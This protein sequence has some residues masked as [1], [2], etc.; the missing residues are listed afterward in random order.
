MARSKHNAAY[1]ED[2]LYG[3]SLIAI[4]EYNGVKNKLKVKCTDCGSIYSSRADSIFA[5]RK[6]KMCKSHNKILSDSNGVYVIDVSTKMHHN[7]K[8][9]IHKSD[10]NRM[11]ALGYGRVSAVEKGNYKTLYAQAHRGKTVKLVH[12]II[13]PSMKMI[14]HKNNDGLDNRMSNL[15]ECNHSQNATNCKVR[16]HSISG[17][18]GVY[19]DK[20]TGKFYSRITKDGVMNHIG[21]FDT[22]EQAWDAFCAEANKTQGEFMH[23]QTKLGVQK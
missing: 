7:S 4:G 8:M 17:V 22:M 1:I 16:S 12:R 10:W 18:K 15:R 9:R 3:S 13:A 5:T 11:K 23:K 14:D 2:K 6:C 19:K 21:T 20:R